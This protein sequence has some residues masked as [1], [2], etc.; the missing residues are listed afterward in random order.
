[1]SHSHRDVLTRALAARRISRLTA[2][3]A[4]AAVLAA[5]AASHA[6]AAGL[7]GIGASTAEAERALRDHELKTL[8]GRTLTL[9][10]LHGDVVVV[11]FWASWCAPCRRELP[12]LGG[13]QK[14]LSAAGGRVIAVSID[15]DAENARRF[16]RTEHVTLPVAHDG[17]DGL[18]KSLDLKNVPLTIVID[19]DGHVAYTTSR[20]DAKALEQVAATAH[21]LLDVPAPGNGPA[22]R[23]A[24]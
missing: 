3:A 21:R 5:S 2:G 6:S 24:R 7:A 15:E 11:N 13:L 10:G 16:C 14:E 1:M 22:A 12:R 23:D 20:S 8:D 18:A 9:G 4:L 19:R 17:P